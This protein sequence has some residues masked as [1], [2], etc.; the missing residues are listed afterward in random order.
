MS[1]DFEKEDQSVASEPLVES[2]HVSFP[3]VNIVVL[4]ANSEQVLLTSS[5]RSFINSRQRVG[6]STVPCGIPDF[7]SCHGDLFP[8]TWTHCDLD[9]SRDENHCSV[10]A[11]RPARDNW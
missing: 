7:V 2:W 4:S 8:L 6:P 5:G 9:V 1:F 10:F 3:M 11:V